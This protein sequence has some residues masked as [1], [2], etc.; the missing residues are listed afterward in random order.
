MLTNGAVLLLTTTS[1][2]LNKIAFP[3]SVLM[4]SMYPIKRVNV[5][6]VES[7][8]FITFEPIV[9]NRKFGG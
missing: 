1:L 6:C 9:G 2:P 3:E 4:S 7:L 8:D 5:V